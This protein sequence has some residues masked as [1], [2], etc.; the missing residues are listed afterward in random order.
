[1]TEVTQP[2]VKKS[3]RGFASMDP[4]KQRAIARKGG[5]SVPD[6]KR[7]FSQNPDLAARAGRKGGQSVNPAKRSFSRDHM[8]ASEAGR[9]GGHASHGGGQK[10]A[11]TPAE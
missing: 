11:P 8:L 1:M 6:E 4:E 2:V 7:S 9:K 10:R 3:N 5:K